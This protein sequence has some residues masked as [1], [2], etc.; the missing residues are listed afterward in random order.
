MNVQSK[1]NTTMKKILLILA[2]SLI[3]TPLIFSQSLTLSYSGGEIQNGEEIHFLEEPNPSEQVEIVAEVIAH[4]IS[5]NDINVKVACREIFILEHTVH[6]FC[7]SASCYPPG[8][9]VSGKFLTIP[10]GGSSE[11]AAGFS[12]H[13]V[14]SDGVQGITR[15][16]YTFF[17]ENNSND[18]IAVFVNFISGYAGVADLV[19]RISFSDA[20]P[21][22]A[23][24][25]VRFDFSL[26]KGLDNTT[27]S[28]HSILGAEISKVKINEQEGTL[29]VNTAGLNEGIYFCALVVDNNTVLSRKLVIKR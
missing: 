25:E 16:M 5:A 29:K 6:Q 15:V 4:N 19:K 23:D 12:G 24:K 13:C 3:I 26:P 10:A 11:G 8:T 21:N 1:C 22:P 27:L 7:W 28:V 9:T 2:I 20:Y 14:V 17:D 18:S